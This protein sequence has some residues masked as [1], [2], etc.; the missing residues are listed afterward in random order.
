M[1][2]KS[3]HANKGNATV[4]G[5]QRTTKWLSSNHLSV[6]SLYGSK[7]SNWQTIWE[8]ASWMS[9]WMRGVD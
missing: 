3:K 4:L 8:A 7:W 9:V 2:F 6:G 1:L 5:N